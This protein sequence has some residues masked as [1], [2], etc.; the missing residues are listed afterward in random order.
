MSAEWQRK[1]FKT[2][3]F[4][5]WMCLKKVTHCRLS[6]TLLHA[7]EYHSNANEI[8]QRNTATIFGIIHVNVFLGLIANLNGQR[9]THPLRLARFEPLCATGIRRCSSIRRWRHEAGVH[10][11]RIFKRRGRG[12]NESALFYSF[13][14]NNKS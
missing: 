14:C 1:S 4:E 13:H 7:A 8:K 11:P 9:V 5:I 2:H 10:Q 12:H 6:R 3:P